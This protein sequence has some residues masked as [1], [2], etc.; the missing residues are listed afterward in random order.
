MVYPVLTVEIGACCCTVPPR[1]V[2]VVPNVLHE[3]ESTGRAAR[4]KSSAT[5]VPTPLLDHV[6]DAAAGSLHNE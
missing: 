3:D 6:P 2:A 4:L 1:R 5:A